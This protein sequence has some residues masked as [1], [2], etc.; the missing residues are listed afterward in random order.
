[1]SGDEVLIEIVDSDDPRGA[2]GVVKSILRR[3]HEEFVACLRP[4]SEG[5]EVCPLRKELPGSLPLVD[6]HDQEALRGAKESDW[7]LARL[8]PGRRENSPMMAE[9]VR[10]ISKSGSVTG[11]L[12]ALAK[13]YDLPKP[14]THAELRGVEDLEPLTI[15]REDMTSLMMVT[16]DPVDAKD[17]DDAISY[18]PGEVPGQCVVGVHIAD[19]ACYVTPGSKLDKLAQTRGFTSYL[20]GYHAVFYGN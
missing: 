19:V 12:N 10:R 16:I 5:Y 8:V 3:G 11:D 2:S 1:M 13:E 20:P 7:V 18:Q 14:F 17:L 9:I 15:P 4:G 6:A